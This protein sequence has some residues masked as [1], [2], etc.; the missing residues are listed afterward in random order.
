MGMLRQ[1]GRLQAAATG[2]P[3]W[4]FDQKPDPCSRSL[5]TIMISTIETGPAAAGAIAFRPAP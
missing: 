2:P 5:E 4:V 1:L 3:R